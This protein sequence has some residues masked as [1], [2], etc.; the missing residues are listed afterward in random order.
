MVKAAEALPGL[1]ADDGPSTPDSAHISPTRLAGATLDPP[2]RG[3]PMKA[4][5]IERHG[6]SKVLKFGEMPDPVAASGELVVAGAS[7]LRP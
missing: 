3:M 4:A 7:P 5:F 2:K 1:A 6:G